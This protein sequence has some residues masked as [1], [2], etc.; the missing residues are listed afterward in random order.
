[1]EQHKKAIEATRKAIE[2]VKEC[3]GVSEQP[4]NAAVEDAP[5]HSEWGRKMLGRFTEVK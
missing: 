2:I 5:I 3:I 4:E 1:M